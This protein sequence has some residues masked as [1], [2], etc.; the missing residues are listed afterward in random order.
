V[1][2]PQGRDAALEQLKAAGVGSAVYYPIPI[3]KLAPYAH[4]GADLPETDRAAAE[5]LSLPVHP[6]LSDDDL[7]RV[8]AAVASLEL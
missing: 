7:D 3:H 6:S 1:R 5:V 4:L 2:I 8:A